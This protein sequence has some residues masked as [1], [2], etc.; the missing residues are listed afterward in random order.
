MKGLDTPA[1]LAILRGERGARELLRRL[2][3]HEIAT[4]ELNLLQLELLAAG[5][6]ARARAARRL[7]LDR[8]R[9]KLTVLPIDARAVGEAARH[10]SPKDRSAG[11]TELGVLGALEANGCDEFYTPVSRLPGVGW[12]VRAVRFRSSDTK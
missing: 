8:L 4:T 7:A 12:R 6:P 3:G 11:S 2:R 9:R 1:L 5:V 10:L